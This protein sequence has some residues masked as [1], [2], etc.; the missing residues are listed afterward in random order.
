MSLKSPA[1]K[2][3]IGRNFFFEETIFFPIGKSDFLSKI[4]AYKNRTI[5]FDENGF[6]YF[7][8]KK[9]KVHNPN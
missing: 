1:N 8:L 7:F 5:F 6:R 2:L 4:F 3:M 9:S